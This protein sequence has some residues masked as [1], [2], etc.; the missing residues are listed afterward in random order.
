MGLKP[1]PQ[2]TIDRFPDKKGNY[3]PSNCRWA[4][5]KEQSSNLKNNVWVELF[6]EKMI[7]AEFLRRINSTQHTQIHKQLKKYTPEEIYN[8]KKIK[9]A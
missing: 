6:G 7:L 9:N 3:E 5:K 1:T 4:T 2:H 8:R